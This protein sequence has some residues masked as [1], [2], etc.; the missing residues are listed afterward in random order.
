MKLEFVL[1]STDSCHL[2]DLA[3]ALIVEHAQNLPIQIME[4]DIAFDEALVSS[5]GD[6]IP[7]L[8]SEQSQQELCWPFDSTKLISWLK[9]ELE[10]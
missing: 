10:K 3:K 8:K 4:Q 5:Y 6:K 9:K 7:V 2:C 1:Y